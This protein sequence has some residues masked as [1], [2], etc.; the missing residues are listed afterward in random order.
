MAD[1]GKKFIEANKQVDREK[2]YTPREALELLKKISFAKFDETVEVHVRT[3]LD[4]RHADQIVRGSAVLPHGTGRT[5]RVLVFA[6]A[7]KAREAEEAGADFVGGEEMVKKVQEG[8]L[9][10]D[11]AIATNDMMGLVGRLGKILGPRG[12]MPNPRTGTVTMDV[13]R[14]VKE[15]KAGRVEFRVDKT[16][17]LHAPIGKVS[18]DVERLEANL[19]AFVD[20]IVRAKPSGAKGVYLR[21]I[22]VTSTMGPGLKLDLST[23]QELA[24]A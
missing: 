20:A 22:T 21:S 6:G 1:H 13:G 11:V 9:D 2:L 3:G 17:V 18:F 10:F 19:G 7:D 5:Q 12:L 8:W 14:V 16:G 23:A 24:A 4:P 15:V